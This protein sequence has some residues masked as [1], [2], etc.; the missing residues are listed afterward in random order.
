MY[1]VQLFKT[2][3]LFKVIDIGNNFI[4]NHHF[5]N[6]GTLSTP[7]KDIAGGVDIFFFFVHGQLIIRVYTEKSTNKNS[8]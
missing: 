2:K 6:F 1:G 5:I 7:W 3:T 4:Q 8:T